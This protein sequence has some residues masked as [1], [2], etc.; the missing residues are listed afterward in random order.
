MNIRESRRVPEL[1]AGAAE[2]WRAAHKP[3]ARA[4]PP[5]IRSA[6]HDDD[7]RPWTELQTQN[8]I[9]A[10]EVLGM[11]DAEIAGFVKRSPQAVARRAQELATEGRLRLGEVVGLTRRS[12]EELRP[13]I[14]GLYEENVPAG[15][16]ELLL[17]IT[18]MQLATQVGRLIHEGLSRR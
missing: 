3:R 8:L 4:A 14:R 13:A 9:Y 2:A 1:P 12:W 16:I 11:S 17:G 10:R 5:L 7:G 18:H 6:A 15:T